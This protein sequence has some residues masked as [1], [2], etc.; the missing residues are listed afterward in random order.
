MLSLTI[1]YLAVARSALHCSEIFTLRTTK[2]SNVE[3]Y[4]VQCCAR[5]AVGVRQQGREAG[6]G[7]VA[8]KKSDRRSVQGGGPGLSHSGSH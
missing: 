2:Q 7:A 5:P 4:L 1:K 6:A 8:A 3:E